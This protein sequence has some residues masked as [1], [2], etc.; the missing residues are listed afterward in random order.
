MKKYILVLFVAV[1]VACN[2]TKKKEET[3]SKEINVY[4]Q[5]HYDVDKTVFDL[6]TENI[7]PDRSVC[8]LFRRIKPCTEVFQRQRVVVGVV[9]FFV[10][11]QGLLAG[12]VPGGIV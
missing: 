8:D 6:F 1:L 4:S 10:G 3:T 5:R 12:L 7:F 9:E 2:P 11:H